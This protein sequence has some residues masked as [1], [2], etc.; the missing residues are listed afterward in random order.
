MLYFSPKTKKSRMDCRERDCPFRSPEN[1][2]KTVNYPE[3]CRK[4][5]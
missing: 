1:L 2:R 4:T 5:D 3:I